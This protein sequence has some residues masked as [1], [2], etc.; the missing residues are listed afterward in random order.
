M[1]V[2]SSANKF[3]SF[4]FNSFFPAGSDLLQHWHLHFGK[5]LPTHS[6]PLFN[7]NNN[8]RRRCFFNPAVTLTRVSAGSPSVLR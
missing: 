5:H 4:F 7:N 6:K 3:V 8:N 1:Q 2:K